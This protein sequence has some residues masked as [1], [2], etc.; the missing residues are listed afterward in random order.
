MDAA[1]PHEAS[2][3]L[4][5]KAVKYKKSRPVHTSAISSRQQYQKMVCSTPHTL[6]SHFSPARILILL[7]ILQHPIITRNSIPS[8][9][10]VSIF[11]GAAHYKIYQRLA[12]VAAWCFLLYIGRRVLFSL[13]ALARRGRKE[14]TPGKPEGTRLLWIKR[15]ISPV[16]DLKFDSK[17]T[18]L[19][20]GSSGRSVCLNYFSH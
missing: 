12:S 6:I 2:I 5:N 10:P 19:S 15:A 8:P 14:G 4:N 7:F 13:A 18:L 16:H 20:A 1:I 17:R 3:S 11:P 9:P